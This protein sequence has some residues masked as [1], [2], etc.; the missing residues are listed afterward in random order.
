[1]KK[2]LTISTCG[3]NRKTKKA[4]TA[5]LY[6]PVSVVREMKWCIWKCNQR[7]TRGASFA[8][9]LLFFTQQLLDGTDM[10]SEGSEAE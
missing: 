10:L 2:T 9:R 6:K 1:M 5:K 3:R 7:M 4:V 8:K